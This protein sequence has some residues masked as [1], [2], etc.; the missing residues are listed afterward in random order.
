MCGGGGGG[1]CIYAKMPWQPL[2]Q[3]M[4]LLFCI[5]VPEGPGL[6]GRASQSRTLNIIIVDSTT[7]LAPQTTHGT[8]QIALAASKSTTFHYADLRTLHRNI[9]KYKTY[10]CYLLASCVKVPEFCISVSVV[11]L[12]KDVCILYYLIHFSL[13]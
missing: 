3:F 2:D 6:M 11:V 8:V 4:G 10:C 1:L 13:K 7:R 12:D 5:E 9:V